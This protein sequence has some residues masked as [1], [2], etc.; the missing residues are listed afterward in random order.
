M[1]R[2]WTTDT[3]TDL[4]RCWNLY[5]EGTKLSE[6]TDD[7]DILPGDD[8]L[9]LGCYT[10]VKAHVSTSNN[11]SLRSLLR[12]EHAKYLLQA[13]IWLEAGIKKSNHNFQ[14]KLLIIHI[15]LLLGKPCL[16][17]LRNRSDN[18]CYDVLYLLAA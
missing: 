1:L 6:P 15:Y 4:V 8:A 17:A 10:L 7:V 3:S 18:K 9:L 14:F 16:N 13:A 12:V 11:I 2:T 5:I